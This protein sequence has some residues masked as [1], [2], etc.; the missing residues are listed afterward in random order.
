MD[1]YIHTILAVGLL[2]ISYFIGDLIGRQKGINATVAYLLHTGAC[3]EAD[4]KRANDKFDR[5]NQE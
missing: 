3:T 5:D 1:P 2:W 4:L